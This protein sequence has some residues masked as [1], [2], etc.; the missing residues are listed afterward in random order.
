MIK[1]VLRRFLIP[2][3]S[4]GLLL[5]PFAPYATTIP[6]ARAQSQPSALAEIAYHDANGNIWIIREY[7]S[8]ARQITSSG[9]DCCA[10]IV[11]ALIGVVLFARRRRRVAPV[12]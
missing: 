3:A 7:G 2:V 4:V 5:S 1:R 12:S 9:R 8:N 10:A 6:V 11:V